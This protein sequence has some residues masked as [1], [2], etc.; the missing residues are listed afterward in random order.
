VWKDGRIDPRLLDPVCRL[1]GTGYASLG[2][3]YSVPRPEWKNV[4]GKEP[5]EV[6]PRATRR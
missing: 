3:L 4:E 2:E 1:G 6:M 5:A